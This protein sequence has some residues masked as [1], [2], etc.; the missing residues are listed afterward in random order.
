MST[1]LEEYTLIGD[2]HTGALVGS[3]GSIDWLC[4]PRFD[5][6]AVFAALLGEPTN[7][8][9]KIA[10]A[11]GVRRTS[12]RYRPATLVV[13][14]EFET[15]DGA[16]RVTDCMSIRDGRVQV[17]RV[18]DGLRGSVPMTM[19][20]IARFGYGSILPWVRR[21]DGDL[22]M[23]AG[24]DALRLTTPVPTEGRDLTTHAEFTVAEGDRVPFLLEWYRS[25]EDPGP[26]EDA[27]Q[28]LEATTD[29]WRQWSGRFQSRGDW[30]DEVLRSL[31]TLKALT[32][33]P[34]GGIVAAATTSLPE[35]L[36]GR[37]ATGTT[38]SAGSAT[39]RSPSTP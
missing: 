20:L 34:T 31:I 29:W 17:V 5:S 26:P 23:I 25:H 6:H 36:G 32:Y 1:P 21:V 8:R 33:A 22:V 27:E 11:G 14:T 4:L 18:V 13:E 39:R 12:Q 19:E 16:A 28:I 7:G 38:A 24:P 37:A 3:D 15:D 10:P 35:Q 2:T 30:Q 9:W